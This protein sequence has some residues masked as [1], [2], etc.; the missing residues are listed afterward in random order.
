MSNAFKKHLPIASSMMLQIVQIPSRCI[1]QSQKYTKNFK[2][3]YL[4]FTKNNGRIF[5][6]FGADVQLMNTYFR[7]RTRASV[8]CLF[9]FG[10]NSGVNSDDNKWI[11][12]IRMFPYEM[13]ITTSKSGLRERWWSC[14]LYI[15]VDIV[16]C[17]RDRM[18][19][20][21]MK[22][23]SGRDMVLVSLQ[24]ESP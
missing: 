8:S 17:V 2:G 24:G 1:G 14:L 13:E 11:L 3:L 6:Q 9:L 18:K 21:M 15:S 22:F 20:F 23:F 12:R 4:S 7:S 19:M 5:G 16:V 10:D